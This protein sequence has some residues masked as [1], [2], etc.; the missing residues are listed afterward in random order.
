[1][2]DTT[3]DSEQPKK[4]G[5]KTGNVVSNPSR[6]ATQ[7]KNLLEQTKRHVAVLSKACD[8]D[9]GDLS[10]VLENLRDSVSQALD[11]A[12]EVLSELDATT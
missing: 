8:D 12:R 10:Y 6:P 4:R 1:M 11:S 9:N 7:V 2:T 3:N 5:R